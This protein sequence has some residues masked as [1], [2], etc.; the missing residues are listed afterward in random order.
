MTI[1]IR[2][3]KLDRDLIDETEAIISENYMETSQFHEPLDINW[4]MYMMLDDA[5]KAF[6]M[7]Y[8]ERIVGILFFALDNYP[9][10]QSWLMAQQLT[11]YVTPE[12]R[13]HSLQMIKLS[14]EYFRDLGVD[15]VI[16]SAR[17]DSPFCMVLDKKGYQRQDITYSKR[18]S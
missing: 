6:V 1:M 14:E 17:Y 10:I 9:H 3:E 12:F 15:I 18:L 8:N 4:N 16:Q 2:L 11:F 7:R 5:F 13:R